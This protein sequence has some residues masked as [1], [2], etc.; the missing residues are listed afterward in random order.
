MGAGIIVAGG[1]STRFGDRDKA[2]ADLAGA[3]MIR[4]VADRISGAVDELVVNCRAD[5]RDAIARALEGADH[6]PTFALDENPGAG[7]MAGIATG[8]AAV[9]AEYTVVVAC[10]MPF[11]DPSFVEFLFE[12][13]SGHDAA[14]PRPDE[15]FQTTQAVYRAEPMATACKDALERGEGRIVEP[16][17][18]LDYVVVDR[19]EIEARTSVETFKNLNTREEFEAAADR[20]RE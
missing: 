7:P 10:D 8:L 4:R 1:R 16:L 13:A 12:R 19:E 6:A 14:V 15:W 18:E 9:E 2:V 11:V 3:P 17:F 5:Q 20:L